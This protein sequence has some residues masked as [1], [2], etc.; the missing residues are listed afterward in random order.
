MSVFDRK[1]FIGD[2]VGNFYKLNEEDVLV[3]AGN[4]SEAQSFNIL[5][6]NRR[7]S[8]SEMS[9][10]L[11]VIPIKKNMGQEKVTAEM[12]EDKNSKN[13]E[14]MAIEDIDFARLVKELVFLQKNLTKYNDRLRGKLSAA[15]EEICD[16]L[17]F[18]ELYQRDETQSLNLVDRIQ[19]CT[20]RRR[21]IKNEMCRIQAFGRIFN[22]GGMAN[23]LN[24]ISKQ[25]D[26]MGEREYT[27]RRLPELFVEAIKLSDMSEEDN[28]EDYQEDYDD[29]KEND[30]VYERK[31]TIFDGKNTNW[32]E[33]VSRQAEFFEN[34]EQYADN[35]QLD[36]DE[37]DNQIEDLLIA[38]EDANCNV[39]QGYKMF[40]KLKDL[41]LARKQKLDEWNKVLDIIDCFDCNSMADTYRYCADILA[42][43][44]NTA[45]DNNDCEN[46]YDDCDAANDDEENEDDR[47]KEAI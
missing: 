3:V 1:Y 13:T 44:K 2:T 20:Y 30:M 4:V 12:K 19:E 5:E 22:T 17:H 21:E 16:I 8:G 9:K 39:A 46:V 11:R 41:R 40:K 10:L 47:M 38:C 43:N 35:L 37:I 32:E 25:F 28:Y 34:I 23:I 45:A 29:Y 31:D 27:P 42:G 15:D 26:K 7:V 24:D 33:V 6:A 36:L 14:D 18:I